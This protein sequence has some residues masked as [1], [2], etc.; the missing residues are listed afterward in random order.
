MALAPY[1]AEHISRI[2]TLKSDG[3]TG[4][5][6]K[7][8]RSHLGIRAFGVNAYVARAAGEELVPEHNEMADPGSA[9]QEH[10]ELYF[11]VSGRADFKVAG[12]T[13]EAPAGTF[14]LV[15]PQASRA[16]VA[17]EP[18]TTILIV[19]AEPGVAFEVSAWESR[20]LEAAG[21]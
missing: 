19:G 18:G 3:I 16:A 21:R 12:E 2:P 13:L 10:E 8:V 7:P 11:V 1:V 4:S 6:W 15:R 17:R 5:D 20:R 14:V 9:G